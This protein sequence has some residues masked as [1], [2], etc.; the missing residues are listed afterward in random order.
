MPNDSL[1]GIQDNKII[2]GN[3]GISNDASTE[4]KINFPVLK[5]GPAVFYEDERHEI[6]I[7]LPL[8]IKVGEQ[9]AVIDPLSLTVH[10]DRSKFDSLIYLSQDQRS[11]ME[12]EARK[13]SLEKSGL[14]TRANKVLG[15]AM[16][17]IIKAVK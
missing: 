16:S 10:L 15:N 7:G 6:W 14:L 8:R 17:G 5:R 2:A 12:Q 3:P 1:P 13:K 4:E 11:L 9:E